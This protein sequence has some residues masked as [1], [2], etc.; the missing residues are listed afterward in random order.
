LLTPNSSLLAPNYYE[1]SESIPL[2]P[3]LSRRGLRAPP[4]IA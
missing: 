4:V 2:S 1:R 3:T